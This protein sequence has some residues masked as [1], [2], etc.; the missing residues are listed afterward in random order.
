MHAKPHIDSLWEDHVVTEFVAEGDLEMLCQQ[1]TMSESSM[2]TPPPTKPAPSPFQLSLQID[3]ERAGNQ[4]AQSKWDAKESKPFLFERQ[5]SKSSSTPGSSSVWSD[6]GFLSGIS[7]PWSSDF[8][9][10]LT[11]PSTGYYS[12]ATTTPLTQESVDSS[13]NSSGL[14][15]YLPSGLL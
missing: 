1:L 10:T 2:F 6:G 14:P 12:D 5:T 3:R 11:S 8:S 15:N 7:S 4:P 13:R 9:G